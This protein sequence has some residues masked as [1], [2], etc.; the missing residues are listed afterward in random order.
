MQ[1]DRQ[2][3][4]KTLNHLLEDS[5]KPIEEAL[6]AI[7][8][9]HNLQEYKVQIELAPV[10]ASND[11]LQR[12]SSKNTV[13]QKRQSERG[14]WQLTGV[15]C[16]VTAADV[17]HAA[18]ACLIRVRRVLETLRIRYYVRTHVYGAARVQDETGQ[19]T[20][21]PLQQPFWSKGPGRRQVPA[22]TGDM[23]RRLRDPDHPHGERAQAARVHISL[24]I[25]VFPE[26]PHAAASAGWQALEALAGGSNVLERLLPEYLSDLGSSTAQYVAAKATLQSRL[27]RKQRGRCD[28]LYWN[29]Q[30][31]SATQWLL[32]ACSGPKAAV[33]WR[34]PAAPLFLCEPHVGLL[35]DLRR[36]TRRQHAWVE[37]RIKGELQHAYAIRNGVVHSGQRFGSTRWAAHITRLQLEIALSV[38]RQRALAWQSPSIEPGGEG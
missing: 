31:M 10:V 14:S 19:E 38:I 28:W 3:L 15:T 25:S 5:S 29:A 4:R 27:I 34:Y 20:W 12:Y 36:I 37:N 35:L 33:K 32:E 7:T 9:R 17:E 1:S 24:A 30:K 18:E 21:V 16:V 13:L 6:L 26:D 11:I 22:L 8:A 23:E 2:V